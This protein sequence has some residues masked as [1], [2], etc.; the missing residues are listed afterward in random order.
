[1]NQQDLLKLL[2]LMMHLIK[3]NGTTA[4][5]APLPAPAPTSPASQKLSALLRTM[6][7][8]QPGYNSAAMSQRRDAFFGALNSG[9]VPSNP[10]DPRYK[11][12]DL[13]AR[14]LFRKPLGMMPAPFKMS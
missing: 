8:S 7:Q 11:E 6:P 3:S 4:P 14:T 13:I 5:A 10:F 12:W 9:I 1:M 2:G